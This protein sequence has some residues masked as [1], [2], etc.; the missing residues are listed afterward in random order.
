MKH[1]KILL[2]SAIITLIAWILLFFIGAYFRLFE[3]ICKQATC[4]SQFDIYL[5]LYSWFIIPILFL[6]ILG[7]N[8]LIKYFRNK[9]R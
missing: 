1:L 4:P 3:A 9:K 7:I 6:L 8:Y 2:I 5:S